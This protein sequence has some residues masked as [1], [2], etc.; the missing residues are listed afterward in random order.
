NRALA[1]YWSRRVPQACIDAY[2]CLTEFHRRIFALSGL[3]DEKLVVKPNFLAHRGPVGDGDGGYA[4]FVGRL[5][6]EKGADLLV[7]SWGHTRLPL[8]VVG[9]GPLSAMVHAIDGAEY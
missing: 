5:S 1:R 9:A 4:L 6:P 2:I 8:K 7:R 3:P